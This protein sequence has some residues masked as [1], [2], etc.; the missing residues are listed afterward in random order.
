MGGVRVRR[1]PNGH[2]TNVPAHVDGLG[3]AQGEDRVTRA[4]A[5]GAHSAGGRA[6]QEVQDDRLGLVICGVPR[7]RLGRQDAE[8]SGA[9][10]GFEIGAG[11]QDHPLGLEACPE[12]VSS[13]LDH[14]GLGGRSRTQ[15]V[16]DV[17]CRDVAPGLDGQNQQCQGV[18]SS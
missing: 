16:V 7:R 15:T 12:P 8:A 4:G 1:I 5:H 17:Y 3:S 11:R 10:P 13:S 6:P 18:S 9:S 14:F 2:Q